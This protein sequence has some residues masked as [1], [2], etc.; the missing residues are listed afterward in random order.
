[1]Y[2]VYCRITLNPTYSEHED[3]V[4]HNNHLKIFFKPIMNTHGSIHMETI[5]ATAWKR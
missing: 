2:T 1:M 4:I 5:N 3:Q